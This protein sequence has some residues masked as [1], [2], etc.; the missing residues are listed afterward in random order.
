[1]DFVALLVTLATMAASSPVPAT[2]AGGATVKV[3]DSSYGRILVDGKGRTVYLFTKEKTAKPRCYGDCAKAWPPFLT[4]GKPRAGSG[5][6]ADLVGS[7]K[8]RS[9]KRQVTYKGH[10]LYRYIG[11]Q[12]PGDIFC[13]NVVEFGGRWLVVSPSGS[14]IR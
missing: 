3:R 5:A 13:Q 8:R 11:D 6:D 4:S 2:A 9:G 14:S 12:R 1:M 7:H 10:P